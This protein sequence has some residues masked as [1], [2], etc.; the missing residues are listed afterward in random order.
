MQKTSLKKK[1]E[2]IIRV[3]HAGEY[4]AVRIYHGQLKAFA[5][6]NSF[7]ILPEIEHMKQQEVRHLKFFNKQLVEKDVLLTA[8]L[9][10][11]HVMGYGLGYFSAKLGDDFAMTCTESIEE[12]I[13]EHYLS[14]LKFLEQ[15]STQN[16]TEDYQ[17]LAEKIEEF[18][19]EELEHKDHAINYNL[20]LHQSTKRKKLNKIFGKAVKVGC[21]IA[22]AISKKI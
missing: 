6:K 14:Q 16:H 9:P 1:I 4:G 7:E 17:N 20:N 12:V 3:N 13:N 11:W 15:N 2:E 18:R 21:K 8:F 19:L 5:K 10:I 22:I